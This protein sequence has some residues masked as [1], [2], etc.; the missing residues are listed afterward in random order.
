MQTGAGKRRSI[1]TLCS[2]SYND[3]VSVE[4][5]KEMGMSTLKFEGPS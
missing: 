3:A 2:F 5:N 4:Q 1:Y